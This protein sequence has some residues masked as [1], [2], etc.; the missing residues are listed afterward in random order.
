MLTRDRERERGGEPE[1]ETRRGVEPLGKCHV[2]QRGKRINTFTQLTHTYTWSKRGIQRE[3][4]RERET[5]TRQ[6][7]RQT[8]TK[9]APR[10]KIF[11]TFFCDKAANFI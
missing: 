5:E 8:T 9:N 10:L 2:M 1:L 3:E 11:A 7:K 6:V 4:E